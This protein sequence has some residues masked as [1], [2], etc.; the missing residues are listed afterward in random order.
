MKRTSHNDITH[1][2]PALQNVWTLSALSAFLVFLPLL[3]TSCT[4]E[5]SLS[6][7]GLPAGA[8][9]FSLSYTI[10]DSRTAESTASRAAT[11]SPAVRPVTASPAA[12]A[13]DYVT[14]VGN[15]SRVADL[16]LLFFTYDE[17]GNGTY[18]T[19]LTATPAQPTTGTSEKTD[20]TYTAGSGIDD[21]TDYRVLIIAN[22]GQY[23]GDTETTA[24]LSTCTG[25]TENRVK[26][27]LLP[28]ITAAKANGGILNGG[29]ALYLL[30]SGE[31][32]KTAGKDLQVELRR[33]SVRIDVEVAEEKKAIITLN[34]VML[35]N[36]ASDV[37]LFRDPRETYTPNRISTKQ[38][39][40]AGNRSTGQLHCTESYLDLSDGDSRKKL[41]GTTCLLLSATS[42]E[43]DYKGATDNTWYRLDLVTGTDG[44]QYLK[45]NNAY[46]VVI[47]DIT[48]AGYPTPEEAYY[49]DAMLITGVTIPS[50]WNAGGE[51]P[52]QVDV[53]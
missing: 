19:S 29:D 7:N 6:G 23:L 17:H 22:L 33:A 41:F 32:V 26:M 12:R 35:M 43:I 51:V 8:G 44:I 16:R 30:M 34:K 52:P 21:A 36:V 40:V 48:A 39:D 18:V 3:T 25:K 9:R 49:S 47:K 24:L 46:T 20:V 15:E 5:S 45:R 1:L 37:P 53:N 11:A 50:Q 38:S 2:T 28:A 10:P 31:A 42:T 27:D 4:G 14:A 13:A